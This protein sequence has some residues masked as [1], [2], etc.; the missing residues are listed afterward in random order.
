MA[1][2]GPAGSG[3]IRSPAQEAE[4]GI[5]AQ[6]PVGALAQP[7]SGRAPPARGRPSGGTGEQTQWALRQVKELE[8]AVEALHQTERDLE[9]R[10]AWALRLQEEGR[11]LAEQ[12]A[13]FRGSRW[14]KLGRKAG[15]GPV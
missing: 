3:R 13:M 14:V 6:Q 9:E 7:R 15:L 10:T 2:S 8:L 5:G 11:Q 4:G 1:W 12:I